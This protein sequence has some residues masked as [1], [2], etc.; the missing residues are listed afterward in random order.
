MD[1]GEFTNEAFWGG[2]FHTFGGWRYRSF[3]VGTYGI[4]PFMVFMWIGAAWSP[5]RRYK[6]LSFLAVRY[7]L[8]VLMVAVFDA[9]VVLLA[10]PGFIIPDVSGEFPPIFPFLLLA[11]ALPAWW[12]GTIQRQ[13]GYPRRD[14]WRDAVAI[15][16]INH[17]VLVACIG[18]VSQG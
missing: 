17:T 9:I 3:L 13:H 6:T 4:W 10:L 1:F 14:V 15:F 2:F 8:F 16:F 18:M 7:P 12:A 11:A 5:F